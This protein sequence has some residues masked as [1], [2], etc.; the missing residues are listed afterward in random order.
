MPL[1]VKK[2]YNLKAFSVREPRGVT[3]E[4]SCPEREREGERERE[5]SATLLIALFNPG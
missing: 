2:M 4:H 1:N 3:Q 5:S